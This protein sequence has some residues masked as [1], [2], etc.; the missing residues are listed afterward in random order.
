MDNKNYEYDAFISYRHIEPDIT[1]A[2]KLLTMLEKYRVPS[3]V[4]KKTGITKIKRIFRDREELPTT[5]DLSESIM[6]ALKHSRFLI[7]ICSPRTPASEWVKKEIEVFKE[8]HG[9]GSI[10]ALLIEGEPEESFPEALR[11]E[12]STETDDEGNFI[13]K[14]KQLELLAADIRPDELKGP[15]RIAYG[16]S[17]TSDRRLLSKSI[18]LLKTERLRCIA[19]MLK[20]KFDELYQRHFRQTMRNVIAGAL[21][22]IVLLASFTVYAVYMNKQIEAQRDEAVFQKQEVERQKLQVENERKRAEEQKELAEENERQAVAYSKE[23][24]EQRKEAEHQSLLAKENEKIAVANMEMA[25]VQEALALYN[26]SKAKEQ[27]DTVLKNQSIYLA[28][29]S[30]QQQNIGNRMTALMLALE[31]LPKNMLSPERPIVQEAWDALNYSVNNLGLCKEVVTFSNYI[32]EANYSPDGKKI[33]VFSEF[34]KGLKIINVENGEEIARLDPDWG[35]FTTAQFSTDGNTI[36]TGSEDNTVRIWDVESGAQLIV[37][38]GHSAKIQSVSFSPDGRKVVSSDGDEVII[39]DVQ[40]ERQ[41]GLLPV[42]DETVSYVCFSPDGKRI[43]TDS[44]KKMVRIW[45]AESR[46]EISAFNSN[47]RFVYAAGFSPDGRMIYIRSD[48]L[49]EV[50]D[51]ITEELKLKLEEDVHILTTRFSPDSKQF[52]AGMENGKV[53]VLEIATKKVLVD[54]IIRGGTHNFFE[55]TNDGKYII[56]TGSNDNTAKVLNVNDG[57]ELFTLEGHGGTITNAQFS[58][59]GSSVLTVALDKTVRIWDLKKNKSLHSLYGS[60]RRILQACFSPDGSRVVT[61]YVDGTASIWDVKSGKLIVSLIGHQDQ[62]TDASFSADGRKVVTAS[63]DKTV[64]IWDALNG[65]QLHVFK[66][67]ELMVLS[68][69]F[70]ADG[71]RVISADGLTTYI[72]DAESGKEICMKRSFIEASKFSADGKLALVVTFQNS[73]QVLDGETGEMISELIGHKGYLRQAEFSPDGKKI[74]TVSVDG[75]ARIWD[76]ISGKELVVLEGD[77]DFAKS[78][79]F[80]PDGKLVALATSNDSS[81]KIWDVESGK[82]YKKLYTGK[83]YTDEIEFS[84]DGKQI[85]VKASLDVY[86][87]NLEK[88]YLVIEINDSFTDASLSPDGKSLFVVSLRLTGSN[89]TAEYTA[90]LINFDHDYLMQRAYDMLK[91]RQLTPSERKEFYI[92]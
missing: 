67:H 62:V 45:D 20:C 86:I 10:Q 89:N 88:E 31:A 87:Y 72:W 32:E 74:F 22:V 18:K 42:K 58:P 83:N 75:T 69:E 57:H 3:S 11:Y 30:R 54:K 80:S 37:F 16:L 2:R 61:S 8:L 85:M 7:V 41:L 21:S 56:T 5:T 52:I 70:S 46:K 77:I 53:K 66:G 48:D 36:V 43:L 14:T 34:E 28:G 81:I 84:P 65:K 59:D 63:Y 79:Q 92:D 17:V 64:R 76:T 50:W 24:E 38:K 29:L 71:K 78:S 73:V 40:S 60:T 91:T 47:N 33:A 9:A 39:W 4:S 23:A 49:V 35:N 19:P 90:G 12:V 82:I 44:Y 51:T 68:A 55:F 1:I 27:R 13:S 15:K 25:K 6:H 26:E